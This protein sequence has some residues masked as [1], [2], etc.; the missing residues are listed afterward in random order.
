MQ[1]LQNH[2][3]GAAI[4]P[5][6]G[7]YQELVDPCTGES[8]AL[9]PCSGASDIDAAMNAAAKAG[10]RWRD[11]TPAKR[12]RLLL[13]LAAAV[14]AHAAE[15]V[16][17]ECANTGKPRGLTACQ[18][19]PEVV[20]QIRF[21]AGAARVLDGKAAAEYVS[22][23][24]SYVR[25]EPVGVCAQLVPWNYPL[26]MATLKSVSAIAAGNTVVLKPAETTPMSALLFADI[27]SE[28]LPPGVLNVVCG[29][30]DSGRAMVRHH[31]PR[32]V[33]LTGSVQAGMDVAAG[34][35]RDLKR[36][37][38]ELGGKNPVL[39]FEDVDITEAAEAI[40]MAGY[41]NAG[42]DC[43]AASRVLVAAEIA[44][45]FISA[46]TAH[47]KLTRTGPSHEDGVLYGPLNNAGQLSRVSGFLDRLPSHT[48]VTVGGHR[49]GDRGYFFAPTVVAGVRQDDEISQD[50]VFGPVISVQS[51]RDEEDAIRS[52]NDVNFGLASSIWT[53]D[54]ARA[55]RVARRLEFG[56]VWVNTHL[57]FASEM[58]HGGFKHSGY[59]KDLSTYGIEEYTQIKHVMHNL[60]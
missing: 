2:V 35:A 52:A 50:E 38:L 1:T 48:E 49:I 6:D 46:L 3:D 34:A 19:L 7:T 37:H 55:M 25:R 59:G 26:M 4:D 27:A 33:S 57:T 28:H 8:L 12:Q 43:T 42:Q 30:R 41:Y 29:D 54:H 45:E 39:V 20:D 44:D 58:P 16:A 17:A 36:L 56:C 24:T 53:R 21:L 31:I 22:G 51:F 14:E 40:A 13:N 15:L 5:R 60:A 18:E 32:M 23:H 11:T 47:A 10:E 9:A